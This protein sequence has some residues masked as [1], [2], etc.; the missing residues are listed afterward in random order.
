MLYFV[1]FRA[2]LFNA[3]LSYMVT[4]RRISMNETHKIYKVLLPANAQY[5]F[6]EF[7]LPIRIQFCHTAHANVLFRSFRMSPLSLIYCSSHVRL[8][9]PGAF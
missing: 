5:P 3:D 6:V 8:N 9:R 2:N 4:G 1:I 7:Q